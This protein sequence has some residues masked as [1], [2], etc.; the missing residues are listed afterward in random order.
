MGFLHLFKTAKYTDDVIILDD[1][2]LKLV[3]SELMSMMKDI[4]PVFL[5]N[6]IKWFLSGGSILGAVRHQGFIPWDDDIDLFMERSDFDRFKKVFDKC[7]DDRYMLRTPG[8]KDYLMCFPRIEK[9]GT[10]V[11]SI[12]SVEN[13]SHGL[14]IDIFILENTYDNA[15]LRSIHGLKSTFLLFVDSSV[16]LGYCSKNILKYTNNDPRIQKEI[17][18]RTWASHLFALMPL[19]RW[20]FLSD[21][22]FSSVHKRGKYLVCPGGVNHFFGELYNS[23][24]FE[25]PSTGLFEGEKWNLPANPEEYLRQRYGS[26]Y[27]QLPPPDKREKH[28]YVALE[29]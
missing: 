12:Q 20:L 6:H 13:H 29:L 15:L 4:V 8:D 3:Q 9:I 25:H 28:A 23:S 22:V 10:K 16:R 14:F 1:S 2:K 24:L 5:E 19:E 17:R 27:M 21:Q 7:L 26:N 11:Q 18:K